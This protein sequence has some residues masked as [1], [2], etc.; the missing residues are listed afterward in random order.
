MK[1]FGMVAYY[2]GPKETERIVEYPYVFESLRD[3]PRE[4]KILEVGCALS[5]LSIE[6]SALGFRVVGIDLFQYKGVHPNFDFVRGS[7]LSSPLE[8]D[9]FDV[10]IGVSTVEHIG[11][12]GF[13]YPATDNN[14]DMRAID[15]MARM[16][17][18]NGSIVLTVPYGI[19]F[20]S[21]NYRVYNLARIKRVIGSLQIEDFQTFVFDNG[22]WKQRPEDE[23]SKVSSFPG[24]YAVACMRLRR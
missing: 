6:L 16:L 17:R 8:S 18:S 13:L 20:T 10:I 2:R 11:L 1:I 19:P 3:L 9:L 22:R 14:G 7:I 21:A 15:Q 23:A 12:Y 24:T 4:A 5:T